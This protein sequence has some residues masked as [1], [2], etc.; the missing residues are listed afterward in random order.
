MNHL[1]LFRS[2]TYTCKCKLS[3]YSF[4]AE[5][6][7]IIMLKAVRL[8]IENIILCWILKVDA[9]FNLWASHFKSLKAFIWKQHL[10]STVM[11]SK[12]QRSICFNNSLFL[13]YWFSM[14]KLIKKFLKIFLLVLVD[15]S[16]K[17]FNHVLF[18][19]D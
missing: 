4:L 10:L 9:E 5:Q 19:Y 12:L 15:A 13:A 6:Y 11:L 2:Q 7:F 14:L 18:V 16:L 1:I 17:Y 8:K 3:P